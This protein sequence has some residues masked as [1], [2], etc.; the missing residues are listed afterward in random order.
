MLSL[1]ERREESDLVEWRCNS[2]ASDWRR[3]R[4]GGA[5]HS[6]GS[7][8]ADATKAF[9]SVLFSGTLNYPFLREVLKVMPQERNVGRTLNPTVKISSPQTGMVRDIHR[10]VVKGMPQERISNRRLVRISQ[11][12]FLFLEK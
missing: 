8:A 2:G 3:D 11:F 1:L 7:L 9:L 12:R 5:S 6:S 10:K 4:G